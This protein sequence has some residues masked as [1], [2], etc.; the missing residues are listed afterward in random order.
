MTS[1]VV[2]ARRWLDEDAHGGARS[3]GGISDPRV[4]HALQI[5]VILIRQHRN[6]DGYAWLH[7]ATPA[8]SPTQ[9][10]EVGGMLINAGYLAEGEAALRRGA[11]A[12]DLTAAAH[13][14]RFLLYSGR[15]EEAE[16]WLRIAVEQAPALARMVVEDLR[17]RGADELAD[18]W[19]QVAAEAGDG[20]AAVDLALSAAAA[21]NHAESER[22]ISWAEE[23]GHPGVAL[24]RAGLARRRG[25]TTQVR[26]WLHQAAQ[27]GDL[28]AASALGAMLVADGEEATGLPLL[29]RAGDGGD[30]ESQFLLAAIAGNRGD[31]DES[32]RWAATGAAGDP[33]RGREFAEALIAGRCWEQAEQILQMCVA[34]NDDISRVVLGRLLVGF[35]RYAEAVT[36]VQPAADKDVPEAGVLLG[37]AEQKRGDLEAARQAYH[38]AAAAGDGR[39]AH[40]LGVMAE[41]RGDAPAARHWYVEAARAGEASGM[42]N[43]GMMQ[44]DDP[45]GQRWLVLAAAHGHALAAMR[46]GVAEANAERF[47]EAARWLLR[48]NQLGEPRARPLLDA[49]L[50]QLPDVPTTTHGSTPTRP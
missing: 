9:L 14:G 46:V 44:V 45:E 35:N 6:A 5:G 29:T 20:W 3:A 11:E 36:C 34:G 25:D 27:E 13:Y 8:A 15:A 33:A 50:S 37:L 22:W 16:P 4:G 28:R 43:L 18:Q 24:E 49:L 38:R 12:G 23:L 31:V 1:D 42:Y 17:L 21:E 39:A 40:K 7:S 2:A 48:A 47:G 26:W 19:S 41:N 30:T 32:A 10:A